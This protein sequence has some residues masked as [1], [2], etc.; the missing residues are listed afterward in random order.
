MKRILLLLIFLA[1]PMQSFAQKALSLT[2]GSLIRDSDTGNDSTFVVLTT[3]EAGWAGV[4]VFRSAT[5]RDTIL[6]KWVFMEGLNADMTVELSYISRGGSAANRDSV[7]FYFEAFRGIGTPDSSGIS[8]HLIET[9][10]KVTDT[11]KV[12]HLSDSTWV[13]KRLFSRYRI[14][15]Y[16]LSSQFNDYVVNINQYSPSGKSAI[17]VR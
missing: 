10:S 6:T 9:F 14:G 4:R 13:S 5:E 17:I 7:S 3:P 8:K 11:T 1:L 12:F 16:E 15:I 2:T